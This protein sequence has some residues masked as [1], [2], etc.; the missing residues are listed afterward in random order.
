VDW[1][2][3]NAGRRFPGCCLKLDMLKTKRK[4]RKVEDVCDG[5][6]KLVLRRAYAT[7]H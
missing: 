5:M 4:P 7:P 2:A 1:E 3:S 6:V